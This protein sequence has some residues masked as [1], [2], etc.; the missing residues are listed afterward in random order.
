MRT[1][2]VCSDPLDSVTAR[3]R[4]ILRAKVDP[5]GPA[6]T[7]MSEFDRRFNQFQAEL[8]LVVLPSEEERGLEIIRKARRLMRGFIIAVGPVF[9][10]KAILRTLQEGADHYVDEADLESETEAALARLLNKEEKSGATGRVIGV[11]GASGGSGASTLAVNIAATLAQDHGKC[12]LIDLK[13]GRGDLATL[14]DLKPGFTLADLCINAARVDR[15]MFE[16][17]MAPHSSGI[18]LLAAPQVF[19]D[20]RLVTTQGVSQALTMARRQFPFVVVDLEDCFHA[21]QI[22]ALQQA[23][24]ILLAS[25]LD[26]TSIRNM[27]RILDYLQEN[28][29][30]RNLVRLV[31]NRFGQPNE[32]PADEAEEALGGRSACYIPDDPKTINAANNIGVPAV[33]KFPNAKVCTMLANL[34]RSIMDRRKEERPAKKSIFSALLSGS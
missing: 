33:L 32:L 14:L 4:P 1:L 11:L 28:D 20:T 22:F 12:A 31:I 16:K 13:P 26:F 9:D 29:I 30:Q 19:G 6:V 3:L 23:S 25:R 15:A 7:Q 2:V 5:E 8:L 10:P 18:H 24:A 34:A 17:M 21:E 27:R